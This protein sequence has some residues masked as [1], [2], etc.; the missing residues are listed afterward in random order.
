MSSYSV[1]YSHQVHFENPRAAPSA[2]SLTLTKR[3]PAT[4]V[5]VNVSCH[6]PADTIELVSRA[7]ALKG[8]MRPEK[9]FFSAV[10]AGCLLAFAAAANLRAQASP[11]MIE[12]APGLNGLIGALVFPM[13]LVWIVLTGAELFTGVIMVCDPHA[14]AAAFLSTG[15]QYIDSTISFSIRLWQHSMAD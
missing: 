4:T 9:T 13:G 2:S 3:E 6:T 14:K 15:F 5:H 8:S 1:P 7:G 11:W 10:S 12:N